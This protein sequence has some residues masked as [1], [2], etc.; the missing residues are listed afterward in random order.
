MA[1]N[2]RFLKNPELLQNPGNL[3]P[4]RPL[5]FPYTR[6]KNARSSRRVRSGTTPMSLSL[7]CLLLSLL[8]CEGTACSQSAT[9]TV[10][11]PTCHVDVVVYHAGPVGMAAAVAAASEGCS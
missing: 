1:V 6:D 2:R 11:A 3:Q 9:T 4:D 8:P 5:W 7:S 10:T